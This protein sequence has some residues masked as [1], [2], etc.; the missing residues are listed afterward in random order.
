MRD[1]VVCDH[2]STD[3]THRVA[4]HAGCVYIADGELSEAIRRAK[5][6]W[7][8]LLEPGARLEQGWME[9]VSAH[10]GDAARPAR[11]TRSRTGE[12]LFLSRF[13]SVGR[14]LADGLVVPKR[15]AAALAQKGL[16]AA[17]VARAVSAR[18]LKA[19]IVPARRRK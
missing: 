4:E 3:Q 13:F 9:A 14:P 11:F 15:Q 17:G 7:L 16:D 2:A 10:L 1:V 19:Q 5:G 6:D 8:L 18:R 12:L